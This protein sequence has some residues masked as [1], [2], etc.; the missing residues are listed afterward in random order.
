MTEHVPP[1]P[2]GGTGGTTNGTPSQYS[3]APGSISPL[4]TFYN[5]DKFIKELEI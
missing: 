5:V 4:F 2:V 3:V 1:R